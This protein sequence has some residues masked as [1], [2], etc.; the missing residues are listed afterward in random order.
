GFTVAIFVAGL[1]FDD[2]GTADLAKVGIFVASA[3]SG[4][5]GAVLLLRVKP[6]AQRT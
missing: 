4:I 1:A 6:E 5:L 3:V 2:P